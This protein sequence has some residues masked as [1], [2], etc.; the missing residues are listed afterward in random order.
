[1]YCSNCGN[2][3]DEDA[4]VCLNC[5][6]ILKKRENNNIKLFN[7]VTLVFSI[8]SFILSFSLFFYDISEVGMYTKA[9]ERIIYGLGFVSTTMFFTIIS[10]I[11]AL[12]D[13]KSNIGKIGLGLTLISI[14]LILTEIFVID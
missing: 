2:K 5:G 3:V 12:V 11:F 13:K 1:M 8:I 14:F 7:V 10:L 4:Y 9:Y 6:V